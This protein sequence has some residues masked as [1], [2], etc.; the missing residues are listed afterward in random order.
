M[1]NPIRRSRYIDQE[2]CIRIILRY[3]KG[4]LIFR[5]VFQGNKID[6][7]ELL[8]YSDAAWAGGQNEIENQVLCYLKNLISFWPQNK[9]SIASSTAKSKTHA[10]VLATKEAIWSRNLLEELGL[11]QKNPTTTCC[12]KQV[13]IA[14]SRNSKLHSRSKHVDIQYHF[15]R[16]NVELKKVTLKFMAY[17]EM[18][19]D[20]FT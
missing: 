20:G 7:F 2:K 12:D 16:K 14:L 10:A 5:L 9:N 4:S 17:E 3:L 11:Q 19:A 18:V 15:L 8:R 13:A 6:K 1:S